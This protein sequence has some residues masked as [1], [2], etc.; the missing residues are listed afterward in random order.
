MK[1]CN[2][3]NEIMISYQSF[4]K[5]DNKSYTSYYCRPCQNAANKVYYRKNKEQ[6]LLKNT[7]RK[8]GLTQVELEELKAAHLCCAI[9]GNDKKLFIDHDHETGKV[10]GL[11]CNYCNTGLGMFFENTKSLASAIVYLE[12]AY[13]VIYDGASY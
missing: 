8:Y 10:R 5:R 3:C 13:E 7:L 12:N 1:L 11:L 9:C 6:V 4:D 2:K